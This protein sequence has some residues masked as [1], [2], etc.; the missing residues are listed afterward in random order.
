MFILSYLAAKEELGQGCGL[1]NSQKLMM[2][3]SMIKKY[4]VV[5][6]LVWCVG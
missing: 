1:V 2:L 3:F 5:V 6:R 4:S